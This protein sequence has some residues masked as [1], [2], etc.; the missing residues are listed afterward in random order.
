VQVSFW[1]HASVQNPQ[2]AGSEP[3]SVHE[4]SG[5]PV[6][7]DGQSQVPA[8]HVSFGSQRFPHF[9]QLVSLDVVSAHV[10]AQQV[11]PAAQTWSQAPQF[12][13]SEST[14]RHAP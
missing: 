3:R 2:W 7:P 13:G 8:S 14:P 9:P 1:T 6:K 11:W 5:Q 12:F 10:P 4:P